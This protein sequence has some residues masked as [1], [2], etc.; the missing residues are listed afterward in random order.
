MTRNCD[1]CDVRLSRDVGNICYKCQYNVIVLEAPLI[2][3]VL[4]YADFHRKS[5]TKETLVNTMCGFFTDMLRLNV[6]NH[7]YMTDLALRIYFKMM[8]LVVVLII[9]LN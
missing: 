2:S 5:A 7:C 9:E 3:E 6:A 8:L 1:K 4:M